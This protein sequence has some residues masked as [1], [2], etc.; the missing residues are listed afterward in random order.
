[1]FRKEVIR[2]LSVK[3]YLDH[4]HI[5]QVT[6]DY[7]DVLIPLGGSE[8]SHKMFK[9]GILKSAT[10]DDVDNYSLLIRLMHTSECEKC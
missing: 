7:K 5:D 10:C 3:N 1:M 2:N 8:L 4:E 6:D 9:H